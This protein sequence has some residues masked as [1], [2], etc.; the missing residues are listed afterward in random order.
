[1]RKG[2]AEVSGS[3]AGAKI[4]TLPGLTSYLAELYSNDTQQIFSLHIPRGDNMSF[5][6]L[7]THSIL[8]PA[9]LLTLCLAV[10]AGSV[11]AEISKPDSS[12]KPIK[13][14][15]AER[16]WQ[17]AQL[18]SVQNAN[19]EYPQVAVDAAG[20]ALVVWVQ[21][22]G[23]N[24]NIRANRY[25]NA[26]GTWG[27]AQLIKTNDEGEAFEPQIAIDKSGNA[28]AV[29]KQNMD[30]SAR[31]SIW[32]NHYDANSGW[33]W[34]TAQRIET[35]VDDARSP[36]IAFDD[37]GNA[38]VVWMQHDG[39][40]YNIWANRYVPGS[41]WEGSRPIET[42]MGYA[43]GD[44]QIAFDR[45]GNALAVW[46][47]QDSD[48]QDNGN[49]LDNN[50]PWNIAANRYDANSGW[51]TAQLVS[52][53]DAGDAGSPQIAI[54][55]SGNAL[56]VWK[57]DDGTPLNYSIWAKR[58]V[59]GNGWEGARLIETNDKDRAGAPQVAFDEAGNALAVWTMEDDATTYRNVWANRYDAS[60]GWGTAQLIKPDDANLTDSP[61]IAFDGEGNALAVWK[62]DGSPYGSIWVNRYDANS[63]WGTAQPIKT[64]NKG[65]V[66]RPQIAFDGSGNALVVWQQRDDGRRF[67]IRG[68]WYK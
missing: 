60:I 66:S 68:A 59:P 3:A 50:N 39:T 29:W 6:F 2:G 35:E 61:Q 28:L 20:N 15:P 25:D 54:D 64:K 13:K 1:V 34:G 30:D 23:T 33:G 14:Q 63:G 4:F 8:P 19:A 46:V 24:Y 42:H 58:Y 51:G 12:T 53:K 16:S 5:R 56:V 31:N 38:L 36:E 62:Q 48:S 27:T 22:G 21:G 52:I 49:P 18:I 55:K 7:A 40:D 11:Y 47:Q 32:A 37:A 57:Q 41:G 10:P 9:I 67:N 65:P 17:P 45:S 44:P 43:G 26:T